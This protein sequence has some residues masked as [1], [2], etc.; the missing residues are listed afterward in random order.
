MK[1][2]SRIRR[3][4]ALVGSIATIAFTIV[5]CMVI[6]HLVTFRIPAKEST[7]KPPH[8]LTGFEETKGVLSASSTDL[9]Q[10]SESTKKQIHLSISKGMVRFVPFGSGIRPA[11]IA[12]VERV[13]AAVNPLNRIRLH[14]QLFLQRPETIYL[15]NNAQAYTS[16]LQKLGVSAS[17]AATMSADAGGFALN[18]S[19]VL[20]LDVNTSDEDIA[21]TLTHESTHVVLNQDVGQLPSWLNEGMAVYM[22]MNGQ[23]SIEN[24]VAFAGDERQ[25]AEDIL[26]VVQSHQ[27][28]PL[29]GDEG[30]ILSG[31]ATYDYELQDWLAMSDLISKHGLSA[32]DRYLF[33]MEQ[34]H[35][36]A[37]AFQTAFGESSSAFNQA[38]TQELKRTVNPRNDGVSMQ[39]KIN[40]SYKGS[41]QFLAPGSQVSRTI[42]A[43]SGLM[44]VTMDQKGNAVTSMGPTTIAK[45]AIPPDPSTLYVSLLPSKTTKWNHKTAVNGGFQIDL[46]NG[47]YAFDSTWINGANSERDFTSTPTL[48]GVSVLS[49]QERNRT[50]PLLK[51]FAA[52]DAPLP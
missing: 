38:F 36:S 5:S 37:Q 18:S 19:V 7:A 14:L 35:N 52:E 17:E 22:G 10:A 28:V 29:T 13:Y 43:K 1:E 46:N 2:K 3:R 50:N 41:L 26:T 34:T 42:V 12:Q 23:K 40:P 47:L 31:K 11:Q 6:S 27:L 32:V 15:V 16:V 9:T 25:L 44:E 4:I 49:I 21:N 30:T 20:P 51:M 8:P 24:P 33:I 48:F 45:R 39:I